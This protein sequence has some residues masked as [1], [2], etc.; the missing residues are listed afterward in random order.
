MSKKK[1]SRGMVEGLVKVTMDRNTSEEVMTRDGRSSWLLGKT[2]RGSFETNHEIL[3]ERDWVRTDTLWC[4]WTLKNWRSI[5]YLVKDWTVDND[6]IDF[7]SYLMFI[8]C[9]CFCL[10]ILYMRWFDSFYVS[11]DLHVVLS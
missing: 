5:R 4:L 8:F 1:G 9:C 2:S 3:S 10:L 11:R 6:L 7:R